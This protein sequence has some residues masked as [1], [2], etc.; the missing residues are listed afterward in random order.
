MNFNSL[1]NETLQRIV[2]L[3]HEAD[4]TY[5]KR[6]KGWLEEATEAEKKN[7][8]PWG[9]RSCSAISMV[10]KTLRSLS[11]KYIFTVSLHSVYSHRRCIDFGPGI[12]RPFVCRK[13]KRQSF[14]ITSSNRLWPSPSLD[15]SSTYPT[16]LLACPPSPSSVISQDSSQTFPLFQ[17]SPL[18]PYTIFVAG[19]VSFRCH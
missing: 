9:G 18:R 17:A 19:Q 14:S 2:D 15:S 5:K 16:P 6:M 13:L 11:A 7:L 12:C 4:E 3:C 8:N 1:P 10:T